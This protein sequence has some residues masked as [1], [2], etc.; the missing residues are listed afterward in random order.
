MTPPHEETSSKDEDVKVDDADDHA[1]A[2]AATILKMAEKKAS[3]ECYL[4][5]AKLLKK[6]VDME[7]SSCPS[8]SLL[9]DYHKHILDVAERAAKKR[10][11][12]LEKFEQGGW[13]KQSEIHGN[14]DTV[15]YYK[16]AADASL[17]SRIETPIESS[18]LNPLL[19]VLNESELYHTWMP[20]F[21]VPRLGVQVSEKLQEAGRGNQVI[22]VEIA[23]PIPFYNRECIQHAVAIDAIEDDD[24]DQE[25]CIIIVVKNLDEGPHMHGLE[26]PP[27][28]R[29]IRRVDFDAGI[30]IR[31]CPPDHAALQNSKNKYDDDG[32]K[33]LLIQVEQMMDAHVAGVPM[34]MIN[35]FTRTVLGRMWG[36]L[37]QV[38][39]DVRD[40]KRP[41]HKEKIAEHRELYDWVEKR[42]EVML[43]K[44]HHP[45]N[46][47][48]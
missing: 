18:L 12:L 32:E 21:K 42:V 27:P 47:D 10:R 25:G 22:R 14:R 41:A 8:P 2:D 1:D 4:Q 39:Q 31:P 19:S 30:V 9:T 3:K 26:I 37:L 6:V 45:D 16:V 13:H 15:I 24:D 48:S 43:N 33:L 34:A 36:A 38:A 23:M 17:V 35:F 20:S 7:E 28:A 29:R 44:I 46:D 11:D 40:G 5:A